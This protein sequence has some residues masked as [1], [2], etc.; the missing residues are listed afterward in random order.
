MDVSL[1]GIQVHC[2]LEAITC[3]LIRLEN[4]QVLSSA[5]DLVTKIEQA[6]LE[7]SLDLDRKAAVRDM[8]RHGKYK[9]TGR[10]KPACEYLAKAAQES[11]FPIINNLVDG[12]NLV[13]L[14]TQLP[15]SIIDID[16]AQTDQF[17][18]RH[19]HEGESFVFN[20]GGQTIGLHDLLLVATLP[21]DEACANPV[22][23]SMRTKLTD[24]SQNALAIIYGP[25]S[26]SQ[27][28]SGAM[29][30]L[31]ALYQDF[32]GDTVRVTSAILGST[33]G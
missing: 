1:D 7:L 31:A 18:I 29:H 2:G 25:A 20:S 28:V 33:N 24:E 10:G 14:K 5:V 22:K 23:D 6:G 17:M 26:L 13:S 21:Q 8:L 15:I 16:L 12:L 4:A 32:G 30:E 19:G 27:A 3:G 11:R 9:P